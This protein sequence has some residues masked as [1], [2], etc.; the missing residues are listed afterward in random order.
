MKLRQ[1]N[2]M[3]TLRRK[4]HK[5][6]LNDTKPKDNA[7]GSIEGGKKKLPRSPHLIHLS[8]IEILW[9]S[10]I[11]ESLEWSEM[12]TIENMKYTLISRWGRN[13][14]N[15]KCIMNYWWPEQNYGTYEIIVNQ[16]IIRCNYVDKFYYWE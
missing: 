16:S 2:N 14:I 13:I 8:L 5:L 7:K 11:K 15:S 6:W 3:K 10:T 4:I 1:N 12:E 9:S